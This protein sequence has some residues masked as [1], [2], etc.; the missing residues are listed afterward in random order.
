MKLIGNQQIEEKIEDFEYLNQ[1]VRQLEKDFAMLDLEI[2]I[3]L[4]QEEPYAHFRR[5]MEEILQFLIERDDEKL[6]NLLYRVDLNEETL[7]RNIAT[8]ENFTTH[9]ADLIIRRELLKVILRNQLR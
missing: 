7:Q 8:E 6:A 9:L 3:N 2:Q 1:T 5:K 4:N